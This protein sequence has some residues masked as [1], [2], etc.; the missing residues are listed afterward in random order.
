MLKIDEMDYEQ[1]FLTIDG[2]NN[3][4]IDPDKFDTY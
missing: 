3:L 4:G 1:F 2:C